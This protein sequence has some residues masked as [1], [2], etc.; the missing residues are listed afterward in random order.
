MPVLNKTAVRNILSVV[1]L[2]KQKGALIFKKFH[3]FSQQIKFQNIFANFLEWSNPHSQNIT[4][5]LPKLTRFSQ[6]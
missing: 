4:K 1:L 6:N 2:Q 5:I 3:D